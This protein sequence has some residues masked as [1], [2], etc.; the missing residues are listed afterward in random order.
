VDLRWLPLQE[1]D[2][3]GRSVSDPEKFGSYEFVFEIVIERAASTCGLSFDLARERN[4]LRG[5][6]E[7]FL[8]AQSPK[9]PTGK[10]IHFRS[11]ETILIV[12]DPLK[13]K[14]RS[15]LFKGMDFALRRAPNRMDLYLLKLVP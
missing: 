13:L 11:D 4:P 7:N 6:D 2:K 1:L 12:R 8:T 15:Q 10:A 5:L 14:L 3:I 9:V